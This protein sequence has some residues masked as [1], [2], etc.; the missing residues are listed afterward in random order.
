MCIIGWYV[1]ANSWLFL[2][3]SNKLIIDCVL[4]VSLDQD[5]DFDPGPYEAVFV[6][7]QTNSSSRACV[8]IVLM[9]DEIFESDHGFLVMAT[10]A[11]ISA[12]SVD[13]TPVFVTIK[14]DDGEL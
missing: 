10:T 13:S 12:V 5:E 2:Q 9:D 14:D 11:T 4:F 1:A 3:V 6:A 8:D 7:G